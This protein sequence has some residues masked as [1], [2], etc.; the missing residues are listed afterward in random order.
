MKTLALKFTG[1]KFA[2][3]KFARTTTAGDSGGRS[4][5]VRWGGG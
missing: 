5:F 2:G 3:V 4:R 1:A